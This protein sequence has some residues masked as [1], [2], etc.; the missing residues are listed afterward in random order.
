MQEA[1]TL[2]RNFAVSVLTQK[3]GALGFKGLFVLKDLNQH[4]FSECCNHHVRR[5]ALAK[6][7]ALLL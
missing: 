4:P 1:S 5:I 2:P 3:V 7:F 6:Y